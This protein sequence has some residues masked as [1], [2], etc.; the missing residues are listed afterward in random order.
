MILS[1][2]DLKIAICQGKIRVKPFDED[3]VDSSGLGLR[4]SNQARI[5]KTINLPSLDSQDLGMQTDLVT[6]NEGGL[7]VKPGEFILASNQE[8]LSLPDN[9]AARVISRVS[10]SRLGIVMIGTA[11]LVEPGF[12]GNLTFAIG[13]ISKNPITLRPGMHFCK[14]IFEP[15]TSSSEVPYHKQKR[16]KYNQE[17]GPTPSR[18]HLEK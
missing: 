12:E 8:Y 4:L 13:N 1:D 15:L 2:K 14:L 5:F 18:L 3:M 16:S 9:L 7:I 10:L 17:T 11:G 6:I